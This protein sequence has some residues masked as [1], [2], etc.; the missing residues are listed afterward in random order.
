MSTASPTALPA[1]YHPSLATVDEN[2]HGAWVLICN[3]FGLLTILITMLVRVYIRGKISPPFGNDDWTLFAGT[4]LAIVQSAVVFSQVHHGYGT[5]IHLISAESL[6][7]VQKVGLYVSPNG[8][9][10]TVC[11]L[12]MRRIYS[13]LR[14]CTLQRAPWYSSSSASQLIEPEQ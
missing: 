3:A 4:V 12:G 5:S 11:S 7:Q 14:R 9:Q 10:L 1:G 13:T 6:S 8:T 2:H